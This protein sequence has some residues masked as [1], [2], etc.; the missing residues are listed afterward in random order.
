MDELEKIKDILLKHKGKSNAIASKEISKI[1]GYPLEDTQA[2]SRNK[3]W[4]AAE[5]FRLPVVSCGKGYFIAETQ[6]ELDAYN[7]NIQDRIDGMEATRKMTNEN[8]KEWSR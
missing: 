5:K 8:F 4:A 6:E 3:I 1:M 2:V 7:N